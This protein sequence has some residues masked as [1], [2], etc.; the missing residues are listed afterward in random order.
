MRRAPLLAV[1]LAAATAQAGEGIE[2]D[3]LRIAK[4]LAAAIRIESVS[5]EDPADFR[6]EPFVELAAYLRETY[7]RTHSELSLEIV[8][9]YTLLF[10]WQGSNPSLKPAASSL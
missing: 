7:P 3:D 9:D 2:P 10:R 8:S 4:R 6:G 5:H 1:L